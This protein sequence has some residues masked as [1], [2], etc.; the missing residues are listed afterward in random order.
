MQEAWVQSLIRQLD[1]TYHNENPVQPN[2]YF[3][4]HCIASGQVAK[5]IELKV[6]SQETTN[7]SLY[8]VMDIKSIAVIILQDI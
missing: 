1:L 8:V 2:K 7:L 3:K 4:N 5:S 6:S